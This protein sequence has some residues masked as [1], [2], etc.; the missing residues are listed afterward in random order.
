MKRYIRNAITPAV[1]IIAFSHTQAA[2][3][4]DYDPAYAY[5]AG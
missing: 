2:R 4:L 5:P 3:A 1:L